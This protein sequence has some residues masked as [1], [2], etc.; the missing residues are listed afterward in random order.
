MTSERL[1][2]ATCGPLVHLS[3]LRE[4]R[5]V[6]K[7]VRLILLPSNLL[8]QAA[9][10]LAV[11][12]CAPSRLS[13]TWT[14]AFNFLVFGIVFPLSH[15][16]SENFR[17]RERVNATLAGLGASVTSLYW[18]HRDWA[19]E[20][21]KADASELAATVAALAAYLA[22]VR[23]LVS[24][25]APAAHAAGL[26]CLRS[27]SAL[28]VRNERLGARA[29]Y[30]LGGEGGMSRLAQYIRLLVQSTLELEDVRLYSGTPHAMR[31]FVALMA[32]VSPILL[33]PY[34]RSFCAAEDARAA[35]SPARDDCPGG[36]FSASLYCVIISSLYVVT[37]GVEDV[38]DG[39][40]LD[41]VRF[42]QDLR[43]AEL[44][45][46]DGAARSL[47][48][49]CPSDVGVEEGGLWPPGAAPATHRL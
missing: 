32:Y 14:V 45:A 35:P 49:F 7:G 11:W 38:L 6:A 5:H 37:L 2:R 25:P 24:C 19:Q 29:G 42:D 18:A 10:A 46:L 15:G 3:L 13:L 23:L 17:R 44:V 26:E 39:D 16:I 21:A 31:Y 28:T 34:W 33:A 1:R 36:Y 47:P 48:G 30:Q 8:T 22:N 27:L 4:L 9:T 20:A 12:A 40:G 41:D 43:F